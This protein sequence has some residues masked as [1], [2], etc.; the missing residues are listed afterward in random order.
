MKN[1]GA[2]EPPSKKTSG[3]DAEF[4]RVR[5]HYLKAKRDYNRVASKRS[6]ET[7]Y[8]NLL[9]R[10]SKELDVDKTTLDKVYHDDRKALSISFSKYSRAKTDMKE[11]LNSVV[12][13]SAGLSGFMG[14]VAC[15]S[16]QPAVFVMFSA[17][18]AGWSAINAKF[19]MS[20]KRDANNAKDEITSKMLELNDQKRLPSSSL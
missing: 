17:L 5:K 18:F 14:L 11:Q 16:E 8:E 1:K 4:E 19:G 12:P 6:Q 2:I 9:N 10:V 7:Y 15:F 13:Y 20:S 3:D